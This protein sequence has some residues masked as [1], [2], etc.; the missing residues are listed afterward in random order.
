VAVAVGG[1]IVAAILE[2]TIIRWVRPTEWE[3]EWVSDAALAVALGIAVYL[4]RHLVAT[5]RELED[6]ERAE[7]VLQ[8]QLSIAADIQRQL[9][10]A[11]PP[12]GNGF[13][14]AAALRSAGKIGGDF[15]D[16][17]DIAPGVWI[18]LV[19]DV[20]GKG[21]PAAMVLGWLR[22]AFRALARQSSD[23]ARILAQLSAV[24]YEEWLGALYVTCFVARFDLTAFTLTYTNAGHP[25]GILDGHGGIRYL[26]RGGPPAGLLPDA[27]FEHELLQLHVGD[28]C[29]LVTD[30]VTEALEMDPPLEGDLEAS[31]ERGGAAADLCQA[32]MARALTGHGPREVPGWDDDRTVVVVKVLA[33]DA[34]DPA[35]RAATQ[36]EFITSGILR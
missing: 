7:L 33:S 28:T 16:F 17:V 19:A 13:E 23:P 25:P 29:L 3:L 27:R 2:A 5:R 18:V 6:R 36:R 21:I 14:W 32:V 24:L 12:T 30:G 8:A 4:W 26:S 34:D 35:T 31:R 1:F 20:S 11:V 22:A 15:Y 9:L 10:P